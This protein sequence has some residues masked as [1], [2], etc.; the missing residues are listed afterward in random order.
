[1]RLVEFIDLL[2]NIE[3]R[4][5]GKFIDVEVRDDAGFPIYEF[6]VMTEYTI[7]AKRITV[8]FEPKRSE[9]QAMDE[10]CGECQQGCS[11]DCKCWC[12]GKSA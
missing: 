3:R 8:R 4:H 12:H 2:S 9:C 11:S 6:D 1:M 5:P 10:T 7:P